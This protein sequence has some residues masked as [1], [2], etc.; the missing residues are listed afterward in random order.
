[1]SGSGS[2]GTG[3]LSLTGTARFDLA[4]LTSSTYTLPATGDLLGTGTIRG[5]G[6]T[7]AVLGS[8]LPGLMNTGTISLA[9]ALTLDLSASAGSVF[10]VTSP[11]CAAGTYDL[12]SGSGTVILGGPLT[13]DFSGGGYLDGRNVVQLFANTGGRTGSFSALTCTGLGVGQSATFDAGTGFVSIVPEPSASCLGFAGLAC[14]GWV[15]W[16]RRVSPAGHNRG[17]AG[18]DG[19]L[20]G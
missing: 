13:L 10:N 9:N 15:V 12:V 2:I 8:F 4:N 6:K 11:A 5:T 20:N 17:R 18:A 1:M 3:G 14:G 7:L 16:R 19:L